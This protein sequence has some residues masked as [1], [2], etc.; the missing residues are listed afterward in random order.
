MVIVGGS[1]GGRRRRLAEGSVVS[2][3]LQLPVVVD[4]PTAATITENKGRNQNLAPILLFL[5]VISM[6][7]IFQPLHFTSAF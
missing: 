2:M 5:I 1:S 6:S 7:K 4:L 3:V